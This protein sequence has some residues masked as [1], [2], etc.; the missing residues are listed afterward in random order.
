[1]GE[2]KLEKVRQIEGRKLILRP[3]LEKH[4]YIPNEY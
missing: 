1:M 2:M 3:A 4:N